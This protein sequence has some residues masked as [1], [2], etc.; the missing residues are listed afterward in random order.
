MNELNKI[1]ISF[2]T[3]NDDK[4][5]DYILY[6]MMKSMTKRTTTFKNLTFSQRLD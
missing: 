4:L 3:L 2:P 1:D 5:I 6:A